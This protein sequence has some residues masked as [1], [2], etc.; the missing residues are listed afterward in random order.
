MKK[1]QRKNDERVGFP[2]VSDVKPS[3]F[4]GFNENTDSIFIKS[5]EEGRVNC[6]KYRENQLARRF[7]STKF[8]PSR[9]YN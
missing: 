8:P 7:F 1:Q 4:G 2:D 9:D 6:P 5:P 3:F